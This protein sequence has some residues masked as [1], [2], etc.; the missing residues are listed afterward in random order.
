MNR[1]LSPP[2]KS[3]VAVAQSESVSFFRVFGLPEDIE[4]LLDTHARRRFCGGRLGR[5]RM[6]A[7]NSRRELREL[8]GRLSDRGGVTLLVE[9]LRQRLANLSDEDG[10]VIAAA[11]APALIQIEGEHD[12]NRSL[13]SELLDLARKPEVADEIAAMWSTLREQSDRELRWAD[14]FVGEKIRVLTV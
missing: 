8:A 4:E 14:L 10:A 6:I 13:L 9:R 12:T 2:R 7:T 5:R 11:L 1:L 3:L